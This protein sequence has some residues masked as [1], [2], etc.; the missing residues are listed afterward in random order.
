MQAIHLLTAN[1]T[2]LQHTLGGVCALGGHCDDRFRLAFCHRRL[3]GL[4]SR[5][6]GDP[7]RLVGNPAAPAA[8]PGDVHEAAKREILYAEFITEASRRLAQA[9][10]HH[11]EDPKV[12]AG[13]YSAVQRMRLA[14]SDDVIRLADRVIQQVVEAYAAPDRT[15]DELRERVG[16]DEPPDALKDFGEACRVELRSLRA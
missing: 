10:T 1:T 2:A 6:G 12:V 7:D 8:H 9:W 16:G 11:A 13:L 3:D 14:S 5:R 15:F 4:A